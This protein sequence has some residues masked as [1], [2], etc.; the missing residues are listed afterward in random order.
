MKP[1]SQAAGAGSVVSRAAGEDS[2]RG[3][4]GDDG[5]DGLLFDHAKHDA[6]LGFPIEIA[7]DEQPRALAASELLEKRRALLAQAH[8]MLSAMV[9]FSPPDARIG[10]ARRR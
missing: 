1:A 10:R 4:S 8:A 3:P 5:D 7:T 2:K 9:R 6:S